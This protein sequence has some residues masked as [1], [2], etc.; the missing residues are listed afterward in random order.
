VRDIKRAVKLPADKGM[1]C[2]EVPVT[3][4]V[5]GHF[6]MD[7]LEIQNCDLCE[8]HSL[9]HAVVIRYTRTCACTRQEC[10]VRVHIAM[11]V[12]CHV[13][14]KIDTLLNTYTQNREKRQKKKPKDF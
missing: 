7:T 10:T 5:K 3:A 2:G 1:P 6:K 4:D 9:T 8:F 12:Y 13:A 14:V 11:N